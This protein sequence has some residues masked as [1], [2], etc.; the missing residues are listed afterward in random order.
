MLGCREVALAFAG[1]NRLEGIK[2]DSQLEQEPATTSRADPAA[3]PAAA[4][5]PLAN[6]L[7]CCRRPQLALGGPDFPGG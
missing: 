4:R 5:S 2:T 3:D 6:L 7:C 1:Q